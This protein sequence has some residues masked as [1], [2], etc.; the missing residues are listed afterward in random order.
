MTSEDLT[1]LT[2]D[3]LT[4]A[5]RA[6]QEEHSRIRAQEPSAAAIIDPDD[7]A[8]ITEEMREAARP[9][10]ELMQAIAAERA[11]RRTPA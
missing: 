9:S 11:R 6:A 10:W 3:E 8:E 2:D 7:P 5:F 4:A 1:T